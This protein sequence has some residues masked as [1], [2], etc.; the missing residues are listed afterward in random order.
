MKVSKRFRW[1]AAHRLP[2]HEGSC[3]FMHGHSYRMMVE[4]EGEPTENT[5]GGSA[6]LIDFKH[7][8]RIV[9]PLVDAMDHATIVNASD[10]ELR[11]AIEAL[12]SKVY[13]M[14]YDSTAENIARH[15]AESVRDDGASVLRT[16]GVHTIRVQVWETETCYAEVEREVPEGRSDPASAEEVLAAMR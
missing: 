11:E 9:K 5:P 10:T 12:E 3:R 2:W 6:M 1:E 16:H 7:V 8:K 15:V 4:L 14:P 13:V